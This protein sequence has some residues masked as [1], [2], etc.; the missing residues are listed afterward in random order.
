MTKKIIYLF[1][2]LSVSFSS[3]A[4]DK[5]TKK[6][7]R[8]GLYFLD[9]GDLEKALD[10]FFYVYDTDENVASY[11]YYIALCYFNMPRE[12]NKAKPFLLAASK[13]VTPRFQN[14]DIEETEAPP[15][16]YLMLGEL[17]QFDEELDSAKYFYEQYESIVKLKE[18]KDLARH[19]LKSIETAK[20][21]QKHYL[22]Y[23]AE[24]LGARVN[25]ENSDYNPVVS[26]DENTLAFTSFIDS[27]DAI[28]ICRKENGRWSTP[29][30]ITSQLGSKG[31]ALTADISAD[32]NKLYLIGIDN[33]GSDI[34]V[35]EF[36]GKKWSKMKPFDSKIN[37]PYYET[38]FII[39]DAEDEVYF[40]SDSP[41]SIGGLDLF[42]S[43][44]DAKGKW[45]YPINLG[46]R[47]N[48][49]Y[50]EESPYLTNNDRLLFFSS[51]GHETMG[52]FDI[53]FSERLGENVWSEPINIGYPL[54]TTSN[55][56]TYLALDEGNIAYIVK[57]I[58]GGYGLVDIYKVEIAKDLLFADKLLDGFEIPNKFSHE[59][60]ENVDST[61]IEAEA[62]E[63]V[64][65]PVTKPEVAATAI[66]A[67]T[68]PTI[69]KEEEK[70]VKEE[71]KPVEKPIEV[72]ETIPEPVKAEEKLPDP[73]PEPITK[74]E[75]ISRPANTSNRAYTVQIIALKRPV[76]IEKFSKAGTV[77]RSD[78]DDGYSRYTVG[79]FENAMLARK[80][81]LRLHKLGFKN[82]FIREVSSISNY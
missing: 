77:K 37:S 80:E 74:T 33:Y 27:K 6:F 12:K 53:F 50:D 62:I 64:P 60:A 7:F 36:D 51:D 57:D 66:V 10:N 68:S 44:K 18:D 45:G 17:Y 24:N 73:E 61:T 46:R 65:E 56:I 13:S 22:P 2:L 55:D 47:I 78:G 8:N 30:D 72:K 69:E 31:K 9:I 14:F 38:S 41:E 70:S 75:T 81:I 21:L 15:E 79:Y 19:R 42:Y 49:P 71:I 25:S 59:V 43:K 35:S 67:M 16:V 40:S 1:I 32:G 3:I 39:N 4:Q 52:G 20:K 26:S 76:S 29:E 23:A 28:F 54:N 63:E 48:T 5:T 82:C 58:P 11:N 34:Y